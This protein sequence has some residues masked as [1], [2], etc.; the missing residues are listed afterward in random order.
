M[1]TP[2][3]HS[4]W[5]D[6]AEEKHT[7][8]SRFKTSSQTLPLSRALFE[9]G[10]IQGLRCGSSFPSKSNP[11]RPDVPSSLRPTLL[12]LNAV[13]WQWIDRF[14]FADARDEIIL[15]SGNFDEE[16]FLGDLASYES[17]EILPGF[18]SWDPSGW[19][20]IPGY[21]KEKW[22]Y[23]FPSLSYVSSPASMIST[24]STSAS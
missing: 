13:H 3:R 2:K 1:E 7:S 11:P 6:H 12:Q 24:S 8:L 15:N 20:M 16:D 4:A 10:K 23:L 5:Y 22:G 19:R 17:F 21:F 18:E 9:N 14:P